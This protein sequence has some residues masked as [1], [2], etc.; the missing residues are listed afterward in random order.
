MFLWISRLCSKFL[1]Y[2]FLENSDK[3]EVLNLV[4]KLILDKIGP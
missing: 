1:K 4:E 2:F 3:V